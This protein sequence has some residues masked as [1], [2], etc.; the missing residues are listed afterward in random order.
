VLLKDSFAG[1]TDLLGVGKVADDVAGAVHDDHSMSV[2][3]Q[4]VSDCSADRP[5]SARDHGD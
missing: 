1:T 5:G 3:A 4:S 2:R